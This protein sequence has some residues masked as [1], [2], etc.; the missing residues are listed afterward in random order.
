MAKYGFI[1]TGTIGK[2]LMERFVEKGISNP[3]HIKASNSNETNRDVV[4]CSDIVYLCVKPQDLKG[5]YPVLKGNLEGRLLVTT[6]AAV[7][8]SSYY[9]NLGNIELVRVIPSITNRIGGTVLFNSGEYVMPENRQKVY[10]DLSK[11][12]R[13][14]DVPEKEL[15]EYTHLAS[16]SP[17]IIS[18]FVRQYL[19]SIGKL[20]DAKG[21][22]ILFDAVSSTAGLL[23]QYG[24]GLVDQVCTK[25]GISRVGVHFVSQRFPVKGLSDELLARMRQVKEEFG[26]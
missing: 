12:A 1:G 7:E 11:I 26:G 10:S 20:D 6:V 22:E 23:R 3:A 15:D 19:Q 21:R 9:Q 17:A 4:S 2:M 18:E 25:Q 24:F 8:S 14:Y 5:V 16:C 13:V